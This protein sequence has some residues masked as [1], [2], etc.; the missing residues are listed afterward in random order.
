MVRLLVAFSF[1]ALVMGLDP[2][3]A[4]P[5]L[6]AHGLLT[7]WLAVI[8]GYLGLLQWVSE[9]DEPVALAKL[10]GLARTP[11]ILVLVLVALVAGSMDTKVGY[12]AVTLQPGSEPHQ[13][14]LEDAYPRWHADALACRPESDV[15]PLVL[16]AAPGGGARAAY[17]TGQVMASLESKDTCAGR[18]VFAASGVSGGSVG[19]AVWSATD[20]STE[21]TGQLEALVEPDA[22]SATV[23]AMLFRD[24]PRSLTGIHPY[25]IDRAAVEQE[26]WTERVKSLDNP[27]FARAEN[28]WQ[29][30]LLLNASDLRTGCKVLVSQL[31][32]HDDDDAPAAQ[33]CKEH[34]S[35]DD[36]PTAAVRGGAVD[37]V[38]FLDDPGCPS[39][40]PASSSEGDERAGDSNLSLAAA[41]LLS[42]RF[43]YVS[44]TGALTA[45][46]GDQPEQLFI[47]DGGYL[48][49]TGLHTLLALLQD[50]EPLVTETNSQD[51]PTVVPIAILVENHYRAKAV[52]QPGGRVRELTGPPNAD[53][54]GLLRSEPLEQALA[55]E[56]SQQLPGT[57]SM[58]RWY[59]I[60]P[61]TSPDVSAPLGWSLSNSTRSELD[62][63][64]PQTLRS[65][66]PACPKAEDETDLNEL[67]DLLGH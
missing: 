45:C 30:L 9:R 32:A 24:L 3:T 53:R 27:F 55:A 49:N 22:L 31:A 63:Q 52:Q 23:G 7:V 39:K 60:A 44:P 2:V 6:E 17:W 50:L 4:G 15:L 37:A 67:I 19:L 34:P 25:G 58:Q 16:V 10:L 12:H 56:F 66:E 65:A 40:S 26:A 20:D 62:C 46:T 54:A 35:V 41:A 38:Q 8:V 64:I 5:M 21:T 61:S 42:A 11:W 13:T 36:G 51:G 28:T 59:V 48:E 57:P 1:L 33:R 43:P 47:A 29:P 18:S 14:T